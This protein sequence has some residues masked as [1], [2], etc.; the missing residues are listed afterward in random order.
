MIDTHAHLDFDRY[1]GE[2]EEVIARAKQ[3]GVGQIITVGTSL[4]ASRKTASIA[5]RYPYVYPAVGIHP[6]ASDTVDQTALSQLQSL[7]ETE[8]AVAIGETGIDLFHDENPDLKLQRRAFLA[9]S[10]IA[11]DLKLPLIVHTRAAQAETLE[12]LR[13][14][15]SGAA[16]PAGAVVHCF[17]GSQEFADEIV[18][19]GLMISFT[20]TLTYPKNDELRAV[21]ANIPL[22]RIMLE[23]DAPFLPPQSKRG[24]RN[25]P[26]YVT[27]SAQC[28]AELRNI[29][30]KELDK[31]T[32]S[33]ARSFFKLDSPK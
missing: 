9:Q 33:N 20:A 6:D 14:I 5:A 17:E 10:R 19:L 11:A 21:A 8:G 29:S 12:T 4:E 23:T 1:H 22:E 7:A 25:E 15:F 24:Q 30:Y 2:V 13:E 26:A 16:Q 31:V 3:R 27:E 28:L 32:S 18:G